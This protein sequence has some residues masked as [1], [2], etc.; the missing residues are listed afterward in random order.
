MM[1]PRLIPLRLRQLA[2]LPPG[3]RRAL[4]HAAACVGWARAALW[5]APFAWVSQRAAR[6]AAI[7]PALAEVR[8]TRLAWAID[9][10]ARRVPAA[11][12]LT[13][14]LALQMLLA[15]A[16]RRGEVVVGV[17][18]AGDQGFE[19]HAWLRCEGQVLIGDTGEL[20]AFAPMLNLSGA[21]R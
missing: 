12:C 4:A 6:P 11:T 18:R 15:R 3:E 20:E 9:A 1:V 13:R 7:S 16:G 8:P 10:V 21:T 5:L 14:A 17:R 19:S 2:E